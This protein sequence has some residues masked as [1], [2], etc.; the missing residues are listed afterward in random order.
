MNPRRSMILAKRKFTLKEWMIWVK[1]PKKVDKKIIHKY[2]P[3]KQSHSKYH[4]DGSLI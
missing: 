4:S 3:P 1:L 2:D